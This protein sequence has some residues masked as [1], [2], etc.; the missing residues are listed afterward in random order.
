MPEQTVTVKDVQ[1]KR[2]P[3][4]M[5]MR[6]MFCEVRSGFEIL[7]CV[8]FTSLRVKR[9]PEAAVKEV[10]LSVYLICGSPK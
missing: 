6:C 8:S 2:L 9:L 10:Y 1:G 7:L 3:F 5:K 4:A